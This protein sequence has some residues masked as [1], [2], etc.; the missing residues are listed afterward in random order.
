M[1]A[2]ELQQTSPDSPGT[3]IAEL[4][5]I[6]RDLQQCV[7][8]TDIDLASIHPDFQ[9]SARNLLQY[10]ALR[11]RDLRPLQA[12]LTQLGLSSLGRSE[13]HVLATIEAVLWTLRKLADQADAQGLPATTGAAFATGSRLLRE[14]S[15]RLLGQTPDGA[16]SHIMVT[17]P[18]EAADNY[19][20]V[21]ELLRSGMTC[22]RINCAHDGPGLWSRMIDNLR[23][24]EQRLGRRCRI[25]MDLAGPKLR[26][27][28]M[29]PGPAV[30]KIRPRRDVRGRVV[31]PAT[32]WLFDAAERPQAPVPADH[33]LAADRAWL[34]RLRTG[35][36]VT[37]LDARDAKRRLAVIERAPGGCLLECNKTV[38]LSED[39]RLRHRRHRDKGA[40]TTVGGI[41]GKESALRLCP[42][43]ELMLIAED[44]PGRSAVLDEQG[45][46]LQPAT[47]SCTLPE[48][49]RQVKQGE[50][51]WFDDGRIGG[52]VEQAA[53][54]GLTIRITHA[55]AAGSK[56]GADKGINFPGSELQLPA[57]TAK[58][59]DDLKFAARHADIVA[60]SFANNVADVSALIE[61]LREYGNQQAGI[62]LKIETLAGFRNLPAMLLRAMCM[63]SCG[64][65][66]AR[67]DLAVEMGFAR[68]AEVQEEILW[69]SEAA[70][71][72]VIWA[73]QVLENLAK[74]GAPTRAEITDAAMGRRA[75]CA[76]LNKGPYIVEAV[77][78]LDDILR[79][80]QGH[81]VKK[82]SMLRELQVAGHAFAD[83]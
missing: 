64:V 63:P 7:S 18:T 10:L 31:S 79:R 32:L 60:L 42:G 54:G 1:Q 39:T 52:L 19:E 41:I 37:L 53:P 80:M 16:G 14:H 51:V 74:H 12:Q 26:T 81:Q 75:E 22:M 15:E 23:R 61:Q 76:S 59:R 73:T 11:R 21:Q 8:E 46:V 30:L 82:G 4:E 33:Q 20:L 78:T 58:D 47:I 17:M 49:I 35:D 5:T 29:C 45:R 67:G 36:E 72:P 34:D 43:D 57:L 27:G 83:R 56:L 69:L 66:I 6:Q 9:H 24:A 77:K 38:Y 48:I 65:M 62:V 28:P 40:S 13:S 70:H 68:L 44:L 71:V 25:S 3:L 55:L 2:A 50:E